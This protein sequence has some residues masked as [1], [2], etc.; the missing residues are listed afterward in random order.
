MAVEP[1][2]CSAMNAEPPPESD[3]GREKKRSTLQTDASRVDREKIIN[4]NSQREDLVWKS[5]P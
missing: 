3:V 2:C 1:R 4:H 5:A